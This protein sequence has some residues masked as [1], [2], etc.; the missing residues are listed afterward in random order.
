MLLGIVTI[1]HALLILFVVLIPF[2]GSNFLLVIHFII[3]PFIILHWLVND[4]TCCLTILEKMLSKDENYKGILSRIIEP[5]YDFKKNYSSYSHIIYITAIMLWII[6]I[7]RLYKSY[8]KSEI[9]TYGINMNTF[10]S[11][12]TS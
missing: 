11:F 7:M 9:K 12:I 1:I 10:S 2:L 6:T 8:S 4:N 3:V 5:V